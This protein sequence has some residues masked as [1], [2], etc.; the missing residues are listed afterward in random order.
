MVTAR[1]V[2]H[3]GAAEARPPL[4]APPALRP[5]DTVALFSPSSH[6]GSEPSTRLLEARALLERWRLRPLPLPD[7][8]PRHL[9]LAGTDEQ[10]ADRFQQLYCDPAVKALFATRGGY[11]A[12]RMLPHLDAARLRAAEP[13]AVVGMSDVVALFAYLHAVAGVGALHGPCL[14]APLAQASPHVAENLAELRAFLFDSQLRATYPCRL[15]HA[16]V[17]AGPVSGALLGGNL[18]VLTAALGTPW[19][20]DTRG[21][22]VFFEE[23]NE[24]P[25]RIDRCL[26]Q[27]RQAGLLDQVAGVVFGHMTRCEGEPPGLLE[28]VLRDLFRNAPY[29]VAVGL[30]AGHDGRNR[31]LPLGRMAGLSFAAS[32]DGAEG[33]LQVR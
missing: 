7:P 13:K 26:T 29:P 33:T 28:A 22:I 10:R 16:P 18:A 8:A 32:H 17:S 24:A 23:V 9:Y 5:G 31:T 21:A 11:G 19:S 27:F 6:E 3:P 1:P 15:L 20:L 12:A 25:Y 30:P 4:R 14:A 2:L